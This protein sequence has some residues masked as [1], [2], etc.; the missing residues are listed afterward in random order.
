[1]LHLHRK[2][3]P[4]HPQFIPRY[5]AQAGYFRRWAKKNPARLAKRG[6]SWEEM[7][8]FVG[9][10]TAGNLPLQDP[11]VP[12]IGTSKQSKPMPATLA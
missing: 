10:V 5:Q 12:Q 9:F 2:P 3:V 7:R 11:T 4:V 6:I 1:M 8:R